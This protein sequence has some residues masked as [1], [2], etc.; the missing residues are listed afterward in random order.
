MKR[1]VWISV[2][3]V[4]GLGL[5]LGC[6]TSKKDRVLELAARDIKY[7]EEKSGNWTE[8]IDWEEHL[9]ARISLNNYKLLERLLEKHGLSWN[10]VGIASREVRH[11]VFLAQRTVALYSW[12]E[13]V[14]SHIDLLLAEQWKKDVEGEIGK[15]RD[16]MK[17]DGLS[18]EDLGK[19][20]KDLVHFVHTHHA[21]QAE[22]AMLSLYR[23]SEDPSKMAHRTPESLRQRVSWELRMAKGAAPD[24]KIFEHGDVS[25]LNAQRLRDLAYWRFLDHL[26]Y[27]LRHR[28]WIY[29]ESSDKVDLFFEILYGEKLQPID[30][31][32]THEELEKLRR[33]VPELTPTVQPHGG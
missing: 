27:E 5:F 20:E 14:G 28:T 13:I 17:H 2:L 12:K 11:V 1:S 26:L 25:A 6:G 3:F 18:F 32:T 10:D 24:K 7:I 23:F 9:E 29:P 30:L 19:T 31:G 22:F 33:R 8:P 4:M 21:R 15:L 16:Q